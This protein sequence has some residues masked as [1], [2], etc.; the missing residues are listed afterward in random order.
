MRE[1]LQELEWLREQAR[2]RGGMITGKVPLRVY[3]V[4]IEE[5]QQWKVDTDMD[6]AYLI[7]AFAE[8]YET[9]VTNVLLMRDKHIP[10]LHEIITS[11]LPEVQVYILDC[12]DEEKVMT[13]H[14]MRSA[15]MWQRSKHDRFPW[16]VPLLPRPMGKPVSYLPLKGAVVPAM[17]KCMLRSAHAPQEIYVVDICE[18]ATIGDMLT[19]L[20]KSTHLQKKALMVVKEGKVIPT[21][22]KAM[23]ALPVSFLLEGSRMSVSLMTYRLRYH[24]L[25]PLWQ[26]P[27]SLQEVV[28]EQPECLNILDRVSRRQNLPQGAGI[29]HAYSAHASTS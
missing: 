15:V 8:E 21:Y 27:L 20:E 6:T 22:A 4:H 14:T 19:I 12:I 28:L 26:P 29:E 17:Y 10:G 13:M 9:E 23:I 16:G 11:Y 3:L 24:G 1:E 5:M 7:K 18:K 25:H 2:Q